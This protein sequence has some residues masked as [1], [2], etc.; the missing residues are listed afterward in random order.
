MTNK[1][2]QKFIEYID[3]F[4]IDFTE[5]D[6]LN[7]L[8]IRRRWS[9]HTS[10]RGEVIGGVELINNLGEKIWTPLYDAERFLDFN[11]F[12]Y[13]YEK[14]YSFI[15]M[16]IL[17]LTEDLREIHQYALDNL[18]AIV[19]GNLYFS[20]GL[21]NPSFDFHTDHYDIIIK[22]IYGKCKWI[23]GKDI[24]IIEDQQSLFIEKNVIHKVEHIEGKRL[25]LTIAL[26][27]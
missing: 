26:H 13:F 5:E 15:F 20:Q 4:F 18:G 17:D 12:T 6:F 22:N 9:M 10:P 16:E 7:L 27:N 8:K 1:P 14:G 21:Q 23:V 3:N 24:R 2:L 25:S 11:K 19:H